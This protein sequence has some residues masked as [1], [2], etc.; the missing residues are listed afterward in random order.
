MTLIGGILFSCINPM[1]VKVF[2]CGCRHGFNT[3]DIV[4]GFFVL[5]LL[6][7]TFIR[8]VRFK[9]TDIRMPKWL[10]GFGI[11]FDALVCWVMMGMNT[12]A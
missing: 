8:V 3:N 11:A 2:G 10:I 6:V 4:F 1:L 7:V 9:E 5:L 12:W